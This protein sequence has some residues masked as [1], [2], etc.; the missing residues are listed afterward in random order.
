MPNWCE[1]QLKVRG[2]INQLKIFVKEALKPVT[3]FGDNAK[4]IK[5]VTDEELNFWYQ[6]NDSLHIKGTHRNFIESN[7]FEVYA[8]DLEDITVLVMDF[9]A[10]WG[11]DSEPLARLSKEYGVDIK[12]YAFERGMEFNQDIE[13]INGDVV[14]D[15]EIKFTD[16]KWEC[17]CP[18]IG[19]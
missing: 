14:R 6:T 12:I 13:I 9:K 1:G 15:K 19:G 8:D 10:A 2:N 11:I 7:Y 18:N 4:D 5:V 17:V 16:Y 3:L